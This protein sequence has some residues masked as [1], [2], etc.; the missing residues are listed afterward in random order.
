MS[1]KR[2]RK[3]SRKLWVLILLC[4]I[5]GGAYY[6]Y[7]HRTQSLKYFE[8]QFNPSGLE[9]VEINYGKSIDLAAGTFDLP[10]HFL[11]ALCMLECSGR[12]I[13]KPRFEKHVY[14]RLIE[15]K[16]GKISNYE[17]VTPSMLSD[18]TD[19]A[20]RNLASSWG[21]F[22]LMGYK[23][24]LLNIKIADIRGDDGVYWGVKWINETYGKMLRKGRFKDAFHIHNTGRPHPIGAPRTYDP[25]YVTNGLKYM[26]YFN[27]PQIMQPSKD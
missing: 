19:E 16:E 7:S 23:C 20:L 27:K 8:T 17:H 11:K 13:V 2:H 9:Q 1:A 18:A 26:E 6:I 4:I 3:K 25:N 21:P 10:P 24:L 22:Q 12:K 15:V 14:K 5:V